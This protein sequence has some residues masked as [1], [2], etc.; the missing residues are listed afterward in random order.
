MVLELFQV[1]KDHDNDAVKSLARE[2]NRFCYRSNLVE[3]LGGWS[4]EEIRT[5]DRTKTTHVGKI[6][7]L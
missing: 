4:E 1:V 6:T 3:K 7:I 2:S 5:A